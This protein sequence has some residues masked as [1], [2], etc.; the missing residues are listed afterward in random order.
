MEEAEC[1]RLSE[2][3]GRASFRPCRALLTDAARARV[4]DEVLAA[5][6]MSL[7]IFSALCAS[8]AHDMWVEFQ[9]SLGPEHIHPPQRCVGA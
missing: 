6:K 3:L 8:A 1:C 5:D 9:W 4:A 7:A 2:A